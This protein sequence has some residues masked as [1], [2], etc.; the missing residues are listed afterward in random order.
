M[1]RYAPNYLGLTV[2]RQM[3]GNIIG[4]NGDGDE[5]MPQDLWVIGKNLGPSIVLHVG[6]NE[7]VLAGFLESKLDQEVVP[8]LD[9]PEI[10]YR[11]W[12]SLSREM[13]NDY[14]QACVKAIIMAY[15]A[16]NNFIEWAQPQH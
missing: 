15:L 11:Y 5:T 6:E 14:Q 1:I 4:N 12:I 3:I 9:D 10:P 13:R 8:G 7:G 16:C 2:I